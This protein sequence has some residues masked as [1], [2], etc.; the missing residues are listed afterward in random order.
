[1]RTWTSHR[2][3]RWAILD[4]ATC[5]PGSQ[6]CTLLACLRRERRDSIYPDPGWMPGQAGSLS[7]ARPSRPIPSVLLSLHWGSGNRRLFFGV[8]CVWSMLCGP[9]LRLLGSPSKEKSP[10]ANSHLIFP[11][12]QYANHGRFAPR[13]V[14]GWRRSTPSSSTP[15]LSKVLYSTCCEQGPSLPLDHQLSS[16]PYIQYPDFH[17][18]LPESK[19]PRSMTPGSSPSL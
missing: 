13:P 5:P 18:P 8:V 6:Y 15:S 19:P 17:V 16:N 1:M 4:L 7:C 2:W 9:R 12:L 10:K 3:A 11:F 14:S